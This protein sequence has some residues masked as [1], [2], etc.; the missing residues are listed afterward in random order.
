MC[1]RWFIC[2]LLVV[3]CLPWTGCNQKVQGSIADLPKRSDELPES[4]D[5]AFNDAFEAELKEIGL[6]SANE[7]AR[8]YSPPDYLERLSWDPTTAEFWG[9]LMS[10][11]NA[12]GQV[13]GSPSPASHPPEKVQHLQSARP[14]GERSDFRLHD[15][16]VDLFRKNGFVVS[17]RLGSHSFTDLYHRIYVHDLPVFVTADS[18]LHAWHRQFDR[19]VEDLEAQEIQPALADLLSAMAAQLP[20]A[21]EAYWSDVLS[22][23]LND[24]DFFLCVARRLLRPEDGAN[25]AFQQGPRV[26][27]ALDA[28]DRL[29]LHDFELF[30]QKRTIDFSQF[31][32][33]GRYDQTDSTKQYFRAV[34]WLGRIDFRLS[35]TDDE[36][37]ELRELGA[38]VVL[39]DLLERSGKADQWRELDRLLQQFIGQ[40]DCLNFTQVDELLRVTSTGPASELTDTDLAQIHGQI[41]AG[42]VDRQQIRGDYFCVSPLDPKKLVLPTSFAFLGQRFVLD[43]WALSKVVFDDIQWSGRKVRRRIPSALDVSFSV[44]ANDHATPRLFERMTAT[45]GV[46]FRD[47]FPYQ[48]NLAA[49]RS[50]VDAL[51]ENAWDAS[52][53]TRWLRCLRE[54]SVPTTS[55]EYP[56]AIRTQAWAQKATATQLASWT[57]LRHDTVL[58]AKPSYTTGE[59][60]FYPAGYVEPIPHF[61]RR[62]DDMVGQTLAFFE[63]SQLATRND[64]FAPGQQRLRDQRLRTLKNFATATAMLRTIAE[65]QLAQTALNDEET[66]FL[67]EIVVRNHL[68]GAPPIGGW[69]PQLFSDRSS[70]PGQDDAQ[71][72]VAL[73]TDVHTDPPDPIVS[74]PGCVLHQGVG[75]VDLVVVAI[76]NGPDRVVYA[77]PVFSHYEFQTSADVRLTNGDWQARLREGQAPTRNEWTKVYS[78]PGMNPE[79]SKYGLDARGQ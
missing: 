15:D 43:S 4:R 32:P 29:A 27:A 18:L 68:C 55:A 75:N 76:D 57:Q 5:L 14:P 37:Q 13:S 77:G 33:R 30:G 41:K 34:M 67:Q 79:A 17:E 1:H 49:V 19:L 36:H 20:A 73:V 40:S 47:G 54:L 64:K 71:K 44:F 59:T 66:K 24:V 23:S 9:R 10:D 22:E 25:T 38:V 31:K 46:E 60:C 16:E 11:P 52:I 42:R 72:W 63:Q 78:V 12:T 58:Y 2:A 48:H 56:E 50:M 65:K 6:I 39:N 7:F 21:R 28:C 74:D 69:Y 61:W 35:G 62:F 26:Q 45:N 53:Y 51:P 3:G 8:R 70:R